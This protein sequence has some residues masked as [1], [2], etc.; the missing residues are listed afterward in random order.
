MTHYHPHKLQTVAP[1]LPCAEDECEVL[2]DLPPA[3]VF[4]AD[5]LGQ[6]VP[7]HFNAVKIQLDGRMQADLSWKEAWNAAE[8]YIKQGLRIYWEIDLGL[9][10]RLK[11]PLGDH[12]QFLALCLSLEH[13]RDTLWKDFQAQTVGLVLYRG[14][15]DFRKSYQ[16]DEEQVCNLRE[17]VHEG[18][19]SVA[20]FINEM[21]ISFAGFETLTVGQLEATDSG[22][23][24]LSLF[25]RDAAAEYLDFLARRLPDSVNCIG[26]LDGTSIQD[27]LLQAQL[28]IK[29]RYPNLSV[30]VKEKDGSWVFISEGST[31]VRGIGKQAFH[32]ACRETTIGVCLPS[33]T[34]RKPSDYRGLKDVLEQLQSRNKTYRVVAE[35]QLTTEWDGL[36]YLI[37][38][39]TSLSAQ[40]LRKL[41]GFCAAGGTVVSLEGPLGVAQ[42][43]SLDE[44]FLVF[45]KAA[46]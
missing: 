23:N 13:F 5:F 21:G 22:K 11:L 10:D 19:G 25:C 3:L 24:L 14:S 42:E 37:V 38:V 15:C 36:D 28:G 43:I 34:C 35:N 16:W 4:D 41:H 30:A 45:S 32:V 1:A 39:P 40:G 9:F 18:F 26:M 20:N 7:Q 46:G 6:D 2:N 31:E 29:E 12:T 17:W 33:V 44:F 8:K 27:P